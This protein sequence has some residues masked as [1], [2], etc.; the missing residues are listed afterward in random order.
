MSASV[1][2]GQKG[3]ENPLEL[4]LQEVTVGC[5]MWELETKL[6]SSGRVESALKY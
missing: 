5:L 3:M 4:E 6:G 2:G 1:D